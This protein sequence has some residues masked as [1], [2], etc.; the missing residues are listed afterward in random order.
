MT[1]GVGEEL[2]WGCYEDTTGDPHDRTM[3]DLL[4]DE[5]AFLPSDCFKLA[6]ENNLRYAGL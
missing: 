5:E 1:Y 6:R 4:I 3:S 2:Y